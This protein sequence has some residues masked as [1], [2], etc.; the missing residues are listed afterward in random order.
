MTEVLRTKATTETLFVGVGGIGSDIVAQIASM[1]KGNELNNIRFVVLDTDANSLKT[2]H[3]N[4]ASITKVQTS[5]SQT[6]KEYLDKDDSARLYWFPNNA[7]LYGK[8]VSEGAGQVR[9][10]SRLALNNA[11]RTGEINK[12]YK[13]IDKLLLKDSGNFKQA[14]RIVV[15]SSATGGTGSGMAMITAMLIREYLHDHYSEKK[16]IIRGFFVLP[17]VMDTVI[18]SQM[19]RNS[20]YRNGYATIKEINAFMMMGSGFGETED[21]LKRYKNLHISVPTPTGEAKKMSCLPFDFCFLMEA[22]DK[23]AEGMDSLEKYKRAA[24]LSIYEQSVGPMQA[25]SFSLEDNIIKEFAAKNKFGRNRFGGIGASKIVYPYEDVADYVAYTRTLQRIGKQIDEA[26]G[27]NAD[28]KSATDQANDWYK[29]DRAYEN[30]YKEYEKKRN[31]STEEKP[32][33]EISYTEALERDE[34]SGFGKDIRRNLGEGELEKVQDVAKRK[35]E[36]FFEETKQYIYESYQTNNDDFMDVENIRKKNIAE[37][38]NKRI[39]NNAVDAIK[40]LAQNVHFLAPRKVKNDVKGVFLSAPS[41]VHGD[42]KPYHLES[43]LKTSKGALHPISVRYILYKLLLEL[44]I[45]KEENE[46]ELATAK[47]NIEKYE[48]DD[49]SRKSVEKLVSELSEDKKIGDRAH[50]ESSWEE[51]QRKIRGYAKEEMNIVEYTI[52]QILYEEMEKYITQLCK[53]YRELFTRFQGK[54]TELVRRKED[55]VG[56][57]ENIKGL[58]ENYL[59]ATKDKLDAI[60]DRV[61]EGEHGFLLPDES[62]AE[63]FES[64]KKNAESERT[65]GFDL[66]S[67]PKIDI[68]EKNIIGFFKQEVRE[69]GSEV[70]DIN[71]VQAIFLDAELSEYLEKKKYAG[72]DNAEARK[73]DGD[74]KIEAL[75]EMTRIGMKLATPGING[76]SFVEPR[77]VKICTFNDSLLDMRDVRLSSFIEQQKIQ[78]VPSDTVS[79][80]EMRFFNAIYNVTPDDIPLF[81]GPHRDKI[82]GETDHSAEGIYFKAYQNYGKLIGPDSMKSATISTHID[83]RWDAVVCLP[84]IN[85]EV[86]YDE[87]LKAHSALLYG[88]LFGLIRKFPSSQYDRDKKVFKLVNEEGGRIDFT[89]S[90]GTD[91]DEFYEVLDALYRDNASS[92]MIMEVAEE[93]SRTDVEKNNNY[94]QSSFFEFLETFRIPE[95]HGGKTSLFEVPLVYY[96][97]LPSALTDNNELSIMIDSVIHII[98]QAVNRHEREQDRNAYIC[99]LLEEQYHIFIE[100]FNN[101]EYNKQFDLRRN[102]NIY[103]NLVASMVCAKIINKFKEV[104]ISNCSERIKA[105]RKKI[106]QPDEAID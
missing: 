104:E 61:P 72:V 82:S 92:N 91:C 25:K 27:E 88:L 83:K 6:V 18:D 3:G 52:Y 64:I 73:L 50:F 46:G 40:R 22:A 79:K 81:K 60:C 49:K 37:S 38:N 42:V 13:E 57:F 53:E 30:D 99:K 97:S 76:Q 4:R 80:Y 103:D 10:I 16:A 15:V 86:Q 17:S 100:S 96:N 24:A 75:K 8:T 39:A 71:I 2:V 56:A 54:A 33:I 58:S 102:T 70:L 26:E 35:I 47:K 29:Y 20:Q 67:V 5:S 31:T 23:N 34:N 74:E 11:I 7:T 63:I 77:D 106:A 105:L 68:F 65:N 101:D 62:S 90:N 1:C 51:V 48:Q 55:I 9:A 41:I 32:R 21:E 44:E 93:Y 87:M 59:C 66:Y 78:S 14:L 45:K 28:I 98:T 89:V 85:F 95:N 69:D 36:N 94:M 43:L 19:E 84:E 12:L